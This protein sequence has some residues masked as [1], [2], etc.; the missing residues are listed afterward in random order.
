MQ[1]QTQLYMST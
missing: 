1:T